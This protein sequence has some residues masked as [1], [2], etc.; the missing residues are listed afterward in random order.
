MTNEPMWRS[1]KLCYIE[2]PA[3]DPRKASD[4]YHQVFGWNI[5]TR[6]DG[7]IAFDD[8]VGQVSGT[9]VQGRAP[10]TDPGLL[11]YVMV[12]DARS[13]SAAIL[14]AGGVIV[15]PIDPA[16]TE[17]FAWF[18]DPDGNVLGIYQQPGLAESETLAESQ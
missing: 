3:A 2:L 17:V 5:R 7:A 11:V 14:A 4:F 12:A 6:G 9:W 15:K 1:G 18:S 8:S 13:A 16:A 10:S